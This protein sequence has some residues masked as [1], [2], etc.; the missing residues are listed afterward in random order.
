MVKRLLLR[1][2]S[3]LSCFALFTSC[4]QDPFS[5]IPERMRSGFLSSKDF[6]KPSSVK[7]Q[8]LVNDFIKITIDNSPQLSMRFKEGSESVYNLKVQFLVSKYSKIKINQIKLTNPN[9]AEKEMNLKFDKERGEGKIT[10]TP[11]SGFVKGALYKSD[12]VSLTLIVEVGD[13][14]EFAVERVI[15]IYVDKHFKKPEISAV[16]FGRKIIRH[17]ELYRYK[18]VSKFYLNPSFAIRQD[19]QY[20]SHIST[21]DFGLTLYVVDFNGIEPPYITIDQYSDFRLFNIFSSSKSLAQT[22]SSVEDNAWSIFYNSSVGSDSLPSK[23]RSKPLSGIEQGFQTS[24]ASFRVVS[25]GYHSKRYLIQFNVLPVFLPEYKV[26]ESKIKTSQTLD[27]EFDQTQVVKESSFALE[28]TV[29]IRYTIPSTFSDEYLSFFQADK[30]TNYYSKDHQSTLEKY[31]DFFRDIFSLRAS[32]NNKYFFINDKNRSEY[33][34][35]FAERLECDR[36]KFVTQKE[37]LHF[38]KMTCRCDDE[39]TVTEDYERGK[40]YLDKKCYFGMDLSIKSYNERLRIYNE[41]REQKDTRA[42]EPSRSGGF[43]QKYNVHNVLSFGSKKPYQK[44][45]DFKSYKK[46]K[47][48]DILSENKRLKTRLIV[49]KVKNDEKLIKSLQIS[50]EKNDQKYNAY[51]LY[52]DDEL[53]ALLEQETPIHLHYKPEGIQEKTVIVF[54]DVEDSTITCSLIHQGD[55][56]LSCTIKYTLPQSGL[57]LKYVRANSSLV[58][59]LSSSIDSTQYSCKEDV[60]DV[61]SIQKTCRFKTNSFSFITS[62]KTQE[63]YIFILNSSTVGNVID[64]VQ[65]EFL[66]EKGNITVMRMSN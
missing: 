19:L 33:E 32:I 15:S 37:A 25:S 4:V 24:S 30:K 11:K 18:N 48:K 55:F 7:M 5:E 13:L 46:E 66:L 38:N 26:I 36:S 3:F 20:T 45:F 52:S 56:V 43:L 17:K 21:D 51:R 28:E 47:I 54:Y 10:W 44:L 60:F 12:V 65:S 1:I 9:S 61:D 50:L 14:P 22:T 31:E 39:I 16:V 2:I 58:I 57:S 35:E 27:T 63:P 42:I 41:R 53:L 34:K 62:L 23:F 6:K 8:D 40:Y 49:A 64:K 59:E 29:R